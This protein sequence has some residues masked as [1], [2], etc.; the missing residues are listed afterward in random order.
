MTSTDR[1]LLIGLLAGIHDG[2]HE[3]TV[4]GEAEPGIR[5]LEIP[6][7]P[8]PWQ[9]ARLSR[10][11]HHFKDARSRGAAAAVAKALLTIGPRPLAL[12]NLALVLVFYRS[13]RTAM[14]LDNLEKL[15]MDAGTRAGVWL[16]DRQITAKASKLELDAARPR[17][18]I[19]IAPTT[20]T[21][22]RTVRLGRS[23]A[24]RRRRTPASTPGAIR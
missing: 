14:D 1:A 3:I 4:D 10:T 8:L 22:D 20:S 11:G 18:L 24:P 6:G 19:A 23:R 2:D 15:V 16:D 12:T 17:T 7:D 5:L 13:D 21:L 9:R